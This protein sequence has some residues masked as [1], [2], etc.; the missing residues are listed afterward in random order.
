MKNAFRIFILVLLTIFANTQLTTAQWSTDP[1]TNLMICD[2]TGEQVLA[3]IAMTSDAGC[4]ISWFDTRSGSYNVYLQRLD[5]YG[6]KL[7][8]SD[9]LL[10]SNHPQDT[11]LTDYD[12]IADQN[13]NAVL[14]F[15]DIRA[16]TLKPVAY[17]ISPDGDFLW[18]PDGIDI[19][20]SDDFQPTPKVA[21]MSDGNYVFAWSTSQDI[22]AI[23]VQKLSDD[24]QKLWGSVPIVIQSGTDNFSFPAVVR[25]DAGTVI[26][27]YT[28]WPDMY[29][30][31]IRAQ[32]L[33]V[34]G[35]L[36]WGSDGISIQDN[37]Q[38][39]FY[40]VPFVRSD[41]NNG[42][43]IAWYDGRAGNMLSSSFVQRISSD[44]NLHFPADGAEGSL[45]SS[46]NKFYP[47]IAFDE[48]TQETYM[49][50]VETDYNQVQNGITGQK[51]SYS[52]DRLWGNNGMVFVP[53]STPNTLS[54]SDLVSYMG[55]NKTYVFYLK[56]AASG[57]NSELRGFACDADGNFVWPG[58]IVT[59]SNAT[60]Q[61]M[62]LS[63]AIDNYKN[64]KFAWEDQRLDDGGIYAQDI[65]PSGQLGE[66]VT[67]VELTSFTASAFGNNVVLNWTT[68][69]EK[70]NWGFEVERKVRSPA[71]G[72]YAGS[73]KQKS[74]GSQWEKVGFVRGYGTTTDPKS[75]SFTDQNLA[76][77]NYEYRLKQIDFDGSYEYSN[78]VE[79]EVN[80]PLQFALSQNYPNPFNPSTQIEY[81]IP[82][83]GYVSLKVYN[84]LGQ[85]V[86]NLVNGIQKAGSHDLTFNASSVSSGVYYYRIESGENV[87]V[88]KMMV[89]K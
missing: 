54:L 23:A 72:I 18:G 5:T 74:V 56:S 47:Q 32:K 50:W 67:P 52:G 83:D 37:G 48:S 4:Y 28:V 85:E 6:N 30:T 71:S 25:S 22:S 73:D 87:S 40:Q 14:V 38:M 44:G 78:I 13:D 89:I 77:G 17:K 10:I 43:F 84:A 7:W 82:E 79:V 12:M 42:A 27:V 70:N 39:G 16:G 53:L 61:K 33:D 58:D 19:S 3:K 86:A 20:T 69:T 11:W 36:L 24:G 59:L 21:Q 66:P 62:Q 31:K 46:D 15:S 88:K 60:Q 8:A 68:A 81:T 45:N 51:F 64:C 34:N 80:A 2:V 1:G 55:D 63:S 9:G 49:F 41:G 26:L 76:S 29:N 65:N 35:Q 57:L 75:Y